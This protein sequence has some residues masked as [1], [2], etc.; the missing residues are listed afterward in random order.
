MICLLRYLSSLQIHQFVPCIAI[1]HQLC[2]Q[3][4]KS[5]SIYTARAVHIILHSISIMCLRASICP[6]RSDFGGVDIIEPPLQHLHTQ[7]MKVLREG[8]GEPLTLEKVKIPAASN[9]QSWSPQ[10]VQR[11]APPQIILSS[12]LGLH[13]F[14]QLSEHSH[15]SSN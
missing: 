4:L 13:I 15:Y 7:W 6:T 9:S 1:T 5:D 14:K 12:S 3:V 10:K 2:M 11:Q 8:G